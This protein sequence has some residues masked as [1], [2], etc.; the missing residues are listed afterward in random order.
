MFGGLQMTMCLEWLEL[1]QDEYL[2]LMGKS[3]LV[4]EE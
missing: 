4:L 2:D 3:A 1:P